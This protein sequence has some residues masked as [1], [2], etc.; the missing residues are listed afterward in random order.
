MN[1]QAYLDGYMFKESG[2][3]K[4]PSPMPVAALMTGAGATANSAHRNAIANKAS[5]S[6]LNSM[7]YVKGVPKRKLAKFLIK[8]KNSPLGK[9][10]VRFGGPP[11]LIYNAADTGYWAGN[12]LYDGMAL[13]DDYM[14]S[15]Q[16]PEERN[17]PLPKFRAPSMGYY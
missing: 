14:R 1:R 7:P 3:N 11:A 6:A 16:T 5:S 8:A 13:G 9:A 17:T 2:D 10:A 15:K 4:A 12:L